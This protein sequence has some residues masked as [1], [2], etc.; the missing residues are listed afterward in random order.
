MP[1]FFQDESL[2]FLQH[3]NNAHI[4]AHQHIKGWSNAPVAKSF[5]HKA[6]ILSKT[7]SRLYLQT[8]QYY[9]YNALCEI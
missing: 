5:F 3:N 6:R 2:L 4:T 8:K 1:L 7:K 9:I